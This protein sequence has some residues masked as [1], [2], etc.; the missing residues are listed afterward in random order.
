MTS[1][2]LQIVIGD[3]KVEF[4]IVPLLPV[5][6]LCRAVAFFDKP[7]NGHTDQIIWLPEQVT[8][9]SASFHTKKKPSN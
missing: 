9:G 4:G 6:H 3:Q 7:N 1:S 8:E 5:K 2:V